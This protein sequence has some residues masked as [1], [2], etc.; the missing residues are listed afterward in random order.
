MAA[1]T[2]RD[3]I[4]AMEESRA[5]LLEA[6]EGL[7][8]EALLEAGVA[9]DWSVR[10]VLQHLSLWEAE[11]VM[12]LAGYRRGRRPSSE[13]FR[14]S[15]DELNAAWH[16]STLQ[17]PL[18]H[19]I[20]DFHAVRRQILRQLEAIPDEEFSRPPR[21]AWLNGRPLE[22]WVGEDTYRHEAEHTAEIRRWRARPRAPEAG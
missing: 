3:L 12:L 19:V 20:A 21:F 4:Q 13:R 5:G 2:R 14:K 15:I 16:E 11:L 10:D 22:E 8:D 1:V 17:R 7:S 18:E 9:G 6:I